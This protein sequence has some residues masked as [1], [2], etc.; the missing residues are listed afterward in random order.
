MNTALLCSDDHDRGKL[1]VGDKQLVRL[2]VDEPIE[3]D[4]LVIVLSHHPLTRGWLGDEKE[5]WNLVRAR[6]HLHVCGHVHEAFSE[7]S[8]TGSG[9]EIVTVVAGA[10]HNEA[11]RRPD[12]LPTFHG[13]NLTSVVRCDENSLAVEVRPFRWSKNRFV[14]D[15]DNLPDS[16]SPATHRLKDKL[17]PAPQRRKGDSGQPAGPEG[18]LRQGILH[19]LHQI[20]AR[21]PAL[22][23]CFAAEYGTSHSEELAQALSSAPLAESLGRFFLVYDA[24][25][26]KTRLQA[27]SGFREVISVILRLATQWEKVREWSVSHE[28]GTRRFRLAPFRKP[29]VAQIIARQIQGGR[30]MGLKAGDSSPQAPDVVEVGLDPGTDCEYSQADVERLLW[31]RAMPSRPGAYDPKENQKELWGNL[32]ALERQKRQLVVLVDEARPVVSPSVAGEIP[33]ILLFERCSDGE[34][35]FQ[36]DEF[37][38][39]RLLNDILHTPGG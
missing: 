34:S 8:Q 31:E 10:A 28:N 1:A 18:A 24:P 35:C 3:S 29:F 13:F 22:T 37:E 39:G 12:S 27:G 4:E 6:A 30:P 11:K 20:F 36:L 19:D 25:D 21:E 7:W 14:P 5:I 9:D 38:L 17:G 16:Q 26:R 23:L 32:R 33:S 15:V 2:F